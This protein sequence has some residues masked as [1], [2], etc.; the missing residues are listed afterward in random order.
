MP[1]YSDFL[2]PPVQT[3]WTTPISADSTGPLD[4]FAQQRMATHLRASRPVPAPGTGLIAEAGNT[5]GLGQIDD[6][7]VKK[8]SE[9]TRGDSHVKKASASTKR[10]SP[11]PTIPLGLQQSAQLEKN[12]KNAKRP[13]PKQPKH[14][15]KRS[16]RAPVMPTVPTWTPDEVRRGLSDLPP[17]VFLE[18]AA[19]QK[20][21]S[22]GMQMG[23]HMAACYSPNTDPLPGLVYLLMQAYD[24][25]SSPKDA[26]VLHARFL[27]AGTALAYPDVDIETVDLAGARITVRRHNEEA[28]GDSE[29]VHYYVSVSPTQHEGTT[30]NT[31]HVSKKIDDKAIY[32]LDLTEFHVRLVDS[33]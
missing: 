9:S 10:P 22:V 4:S 5:S 21:A 33:P 24:N 11:A 25:F 20:D 6:S 15:A 16:R 23:Q 30:L 31:Y 8:A 3:S 13:Q 27:Q 32:A 28:T 18:L 12:A 26:E 7:Q 19:L 2:R 1:P 14:T 17:T 29:P